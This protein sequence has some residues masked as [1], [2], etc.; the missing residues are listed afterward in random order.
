MAA[1]LACTECNSTLQ[2]DWEAQTIQK[3]A[4]RDVSC[5]ASW[6]QLAHRNALQLAAVC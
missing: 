2:E 1:L 5:F 3:V 4:D 6:L